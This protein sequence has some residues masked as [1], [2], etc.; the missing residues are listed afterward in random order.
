M[1]FPLRSE[2]E[3]AL[4][5]VRI[6]ARP[7]DLESVTLDFKRPKDSF[8]D[9]ARD[10]AEAVACSANAS[11][12]AVVVGIDDKKTGQAAF[13]G[14][15][16]DAEALRRRIW[17]LTNP[18]LTVTADTTRA[19]DADLVVLLIPE[20]L[21]VHTV[22]GRASHRVDRSCEPMSASEQARL[23]DDRR[24]FDWSAEPTER[25]AGD[26]SPL[27]L[28]TARQ[29]LRTHPDPQRQ[30]YAGPNDADLLR[31]LGVATS[32]GQLLRAGELLF[33]DTGGRDLLA[34]QFR[35][36]P[37]REP[38]DIQRLSGPLL[39]GLQRVLE[40]ITARIDR[41]P[42]L[43]PSGQQV[44]LADLPEGPV[45]EALVN[46]V[47]HRDWRLPEP[48]SVEHAPTRLVVDSPG[49]LVLGVT[50]DN[51]LAHPSKPRNRVLTEAI[52]KLGLAEQA[53]VG[54]DRMYRDMIRSGH[55]PPQILVSDSVRV[56]LTGG[57]PNK[58]LARYV[59]TL[60]ETV[61]DDVDAML[62]LFTLLS[63]RTTTASGL[64]SVIQKPVD[65]VEVALRML[66]ADEVAMLEPTRQ[67]A[68]RKNPSYRLRGDALKELGTAVTYRR[69]T[70]DEIDRK[71]IATVNEIG[72]ITNG[73]VQALFDVKVERASRI[74]SDLVDRDIL[75][76]TSPHERGP[77]VTNGPG[78]KFP[79]RKASRR[80]APEPNTGAQLAFE[81]DDGDV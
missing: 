77:R 21:E 54:I 32:A 2:V 67:T 81:A 1:A 3:E 50:V 60:P 55:Q 58:P 29:L 17:E 34:Y 37:G 10:L 46:A 16:H 62:V 23:I 24:G 71:I 74:L 51:I 40:L 73:V 7:A 6:G 14:C 26:A 12:G 66:A 47:A 63:H 53:G 18:S 27:A 64:E 13:V 79:T 70:A 69:R 5:A 72:Q 57:A 38:A 9:T 41:T 20:G 78:A 28:A 49:P 19:G 52:R 11:G 68:R 31:A 15:G 39:L 56:T 59:A 30:A 65:E 35:R 76:K 33:C 43:L 36:S 44:H 22:A 4:E 80:R 75:V 42:I 45:R 8:E 48:I 25:A 61:A